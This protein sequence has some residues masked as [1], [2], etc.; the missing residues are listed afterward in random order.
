MIE[1]DWEPP[2]T[3]F[4]D[5]IAHEICASESLLSVTTS[6]FEP[7]ISIQALTGFACSRTVH[8]VGHVGKMTL[9]VIIDTGSTH[10]LL[11]PT[12][13]CRLGH[14]IDVSKQPKCIQVA[15]NNFTETKGFVPKFHV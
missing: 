4:E 1:A 14:N 11:N 12:I 9:N 13:A 2:A 6:D 8:I 3:S 15:N 7:S 5:I 10:N